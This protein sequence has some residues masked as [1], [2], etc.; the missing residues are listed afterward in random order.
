MKTSI[1][2]LIVCACLGFRS[3]DLKAQK[4][5]RVGVAGLSHDHAHAVMNQYTNG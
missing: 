5:L 1:F 4:I 3:S 2:C